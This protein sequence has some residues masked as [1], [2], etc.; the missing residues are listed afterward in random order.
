M[1]PHPSPRME[2]KAMSSPDL[3]AFS[4][5]KILVCQQ[6]Q[7][8]D[9]LLATPVFEL[10]KRRYPQAELHLF[11]EKKC[12]P[13]LRHNPYI[14]AFHLID[15]QKGFFGQIAFY[16]KVAQQRFDMA[17]NFQQLPRCRMMTW[18]THAP[19]RLSYDTG[20]WNNRIYTHVVPEKKGY[21][22]L[23]KASL[24]EC[25]G[26][27]WQGEP[28][29]IWLTEEEE[30]QACDLLRQCGFEGGQ[31]LITIDATH[32]RAT[33]RWPPENY[34]ELIGLLAGS[35]P[36]LRFFLL[37][38]PGEDADVLHLRSLCKE[39]DRI[40]LPPQVPDLRLSAACIKKAVLHIGNCSAPRHMAVA[41]G[42]PS[43]TL[44]GASGPLWTYPGPLHAHM[45]AG[46]SCCPCDKTECS[47]MR[48][49]TLIT[50]EMVFE[51][52]LGLLHKAAVRN[53]AH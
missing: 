9:V 37:R 27:R 22:C 51:K 26:L 31:Q 52:A 8:G 7:L 21:A 25:L 36:D 13:L 34:A 20:F 12:V 17:I 48:C 35:D 39:Q 45:S 29:R 1:F 43:L 44:T 28:P 53:L 16:R 32:R 49:M 15:K 5:R 41:C 23:A 40:F 42:T 4:P 47:D 10:L 50:P 6:R 11:T 2:S 46:L 24:L 18:F 38:G 19:V 14:D 30:E 3:S 33:K